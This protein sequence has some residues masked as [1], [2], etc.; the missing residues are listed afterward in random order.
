MDAILGFL[1]HPIVITILTIV[2]GLLGTYAPKFKQFPTAAISFLNA[3]LAFL[4]KVG[5]PAEAHADVLYVVGVIPIAALGTGLLATIGASVWQS[6]Q[7]YL[8]FKVFLHDPIEK[9]LKI[10]KQEPAG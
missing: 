9:G 6:V 3:L 8:L 1:N 2:V 10:P 5:A 7:S 4:I